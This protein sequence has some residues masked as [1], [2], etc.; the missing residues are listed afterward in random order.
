MRGS[1]VAGNDVGGS[2]N[3]LSFVL[4]ADIVYD[5]HVFGS[6]D[7]DGLFSCVSLLNPL[8]CGRRV[9]FSLADEHGP[10]VECSYD[11]ALGSHSYY[12]R[13]NCNS[14]MSNN[15]PC[16]LFT[17]YS[18]LLILSYFFHSIK[19]YF[20]LFTLSFSLSLLQQL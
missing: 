2:A 8:I 5:E 3:V 9:A 4:I 16:Q 11:G 12:F 18:T 7:V 10:I 14:Q 17:P 13:W 20:L 1:L 6:T 15:N 19:S